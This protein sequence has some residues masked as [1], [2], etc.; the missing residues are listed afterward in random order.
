MK[1]L[2]ITILVIAFLVGAAALGAHIYRSNKKN[3]DPVNVYSVGNWLGNYYDTETSLSGTVVL[4]DEQT[5]YIERD[6]IIKE[7]YATPGDAVKVGDVLIEYDTTQEQLKLNTM[8]AQLS[9]TET[10]LKLA[11]NQ[12]AKLQSITPI[13]DDAEIP[14]SPA[15]QAYDEATE[16]LNEAE[17]AC[18]EP[19]ADYSGA[20][21]NANTIASTMNDA[22]AK[23]NTCKEDVEVAQ[24]AIDIFTNTVPEDYDKESDKYKKA[25]N[26]IYEDE[27]IKD[28]DESEQLIALNTRLVDAQNDEKEANKDFEEISFAFSEAQIVLKEAEDKL[29]A[30]H[31]TV[32][33]AQAK[34]DAAYEAYMKEQEEQL[35]N[36]T[37][38]YTE[39]ELKRAI[40][41][42]NEEIK[43]LNLS[44]AN[45]SLAIKRQQK[46]IE[47][48]KVVSEL[49]GIIQVCNIT[50]ESIAGGQPAIVV[51]A[52]GAYSARVSVDEFSLDEMQIG[53]EVTILSYDTGNTY[54]GKVSKKSEAPSESDYNYYDYTA[55]SYPVTIV[56]QDGDDLYEGMWVEVTRAS[57]FNFESKAGEIVLPLALCK[58]EKGGYYVMKREG[59]R[60]KKQYVSTGK[61]YWGQYIVIKSGLK[62][63][64]FIAFPYAKDAVEGKV[65]KEAEISDLYDY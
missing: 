62:A 51:S 15:E 26:S 56:I 35:E 9:V 40:R 2:L 43:D 52:E 48:G 28:M 24:L 25:Y 42:K 65:C 38:I 31:K 30:A 61:I 60:L 37:P 58:K 49:D 53:D 27:Y 50:E 18:I 19:E 34:F 64:D 14:K 55:S 7:I 20:E 63:G 57:D 59:D 46:V 39:T 22:E 32:E 29:N 6:K 33:D 12:L 13:P 10:D 17:K 21:A 45:Q 36:P 16:A 5:V 44:V 47:K 54:F 1:K 41:L 23:Y 4:S 11:N 3:S 8:S